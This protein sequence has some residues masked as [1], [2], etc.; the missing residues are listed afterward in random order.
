MSLGKKKIQMQ[1]AAGI[2]GTDHFTPF[3]YTGTG[4][5]SSTSF[6]GVGFNP[7]MVWVKT[8]RLFHSA[9]G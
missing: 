2:T 4:S 5:S 3:L 8:L 7:D 1:G 6:T 9:N